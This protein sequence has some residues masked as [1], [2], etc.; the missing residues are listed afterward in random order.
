MLAGVWTWVRL[1]PA[2][3]FPLHSFAFLGKTLLNQRFYFVYG[4]PFY[5]FCEKR[6]TTK[7]LQTD[8]IFKKGIPKRI[9]HFCRILKS[10][11]FTKRFLASLCVFVIFRTC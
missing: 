9:L 1:P 2:P 6:D 11:Y 3:L 7:E 10:V 8:S 4:V 5:S